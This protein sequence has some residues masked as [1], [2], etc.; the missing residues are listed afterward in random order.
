M[1]REYFKELVNTKRDPVVFESGEVII[2]EGSEINELLIMI[3]GKAKVI[4][5]YENGKQLLI[6][7][8]KPINLLGDVE[9]ICAKKEASCTVIA[10]SRCLFAKISFE[11]LDSH[12]KDNLIF[13]QNLLRYTSE[14]LLVS[15]SKNALNVIYDV[16]TKLAS[17]LL[18]VEKNNKAKLVN[19]EELSAYLGTSYRHI[20]RCLSD[21]IARKIIDK[22]KKYVT[23]TN[24]MELQKL[25]RNNV[26]EID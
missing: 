12:Y 17:Y 1:S 7:F 14:K 26:Y 20:N 3:E 25:S 23:I 19:Q 15:S 2:Y 11:E 9:Y 8:L 10:T 22:D 18:S 16:K 24:K 4:Q 21:L 13:N 5:N 6:Q